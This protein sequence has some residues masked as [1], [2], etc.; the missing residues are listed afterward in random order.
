MPQTADGTRLWPGGRQAFCPSSPVYREHAVRLC[1]V[2][3][4]R[5]GAHP[6]LR[7][8]HVG[9]EL[10]CHNALC[11]CDV[12][13]AA[14]RTWL[15]ERYGDVAELNRVWGTAFWSQR[16]GSFD[17]VLPPRTVTA[18]AN[19][20]QQL[21]FRRFSSDQHL[22]NFVA[23][24]DVLHEL[25]ARRAGHHELHGHQPHPRARLPPLGRRDG[26]RSPTTST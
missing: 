23:E 10:G 18:T 21:D 26:R 19:P 20:T 2:L 24:R 14:F 16:Y 1:R 15:A 25:L 11:Y 9:N 22:A 13:A 17:E 12:S 3:A 8:W 5:Y 6:A 7:L 4:E